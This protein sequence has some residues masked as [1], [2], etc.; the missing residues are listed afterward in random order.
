M[1]KRLFLINTINK[2]MDIIYNPFAKP[3]MEENP[4]IEVFNICDDSLLVDT[5]KNGDMPN[6][7]AARLINY[8]FCAEKAGA[9]AVMLTCTSVSEVAKYARRFAGIPVFSIV[10]P[11]IKQAV[12]GGSKIGVIGTLPTSP[13]A[14]V[15]LLEEQAK[16]VGKNIQI[17]TKV[18]EG[19]YDILISGNVKKHDDMV[20]LELK[21]FAKEVDVI[22]F[23][24]IS[25]SR[26]VHEDCGKPVFKIGKS[27]FDEAAR[28][29]GGADF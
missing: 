18:V 15:P 17:V 6:D 5:L 14:I 23:A 27:G 12:N 4:D 9:S 19:A 3:F 26:M 1:K 24:Q 10:E 20:N 7:V 29:L 28:I 22:V 16:S 21:K 2:F 11:M 25:M 8:V 13:L